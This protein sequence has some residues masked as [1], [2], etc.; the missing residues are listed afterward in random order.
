MVNSQD[1]LLL[2][3]PFQGT[4]SYLFGFSVVR[5]EKQAPGGGKTRG[6]GT[7]KRCSHKWFHT[8]QCSLARTLAQIFFVPCLCPP[9]PPPTPKP[10]SVANQ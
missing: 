3:C 5:V 10:R 1:A 2:G 7:K 8:V 9:R 4:R 6:S